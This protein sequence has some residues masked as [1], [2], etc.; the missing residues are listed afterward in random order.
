MES[1]KPQN[2]SR[3]VTKEQQIYRDLTFQLHM[4]MLSGLQ[5]QLHTT[6]KLGWTS[7]HNLILEAIKTCSRKLMAW[8]CYVTQHHMHSTIALTRKS[9]RGN[10]SSPPPR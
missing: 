1:S 4:F 2:N 7:G 6:R 8:Q 10:F 5:W 3:R 9:L